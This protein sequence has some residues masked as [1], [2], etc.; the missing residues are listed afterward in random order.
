MANVNHSALTDPYLHEPKGVATASAGEVYVA[1]GSGSGS[2]KEAH[3][4][5]GAYI[6]FDAT[7]PAYQHSTT[8]S[9]T[10]LNPTFTVSV[11]DGF[12]GLTSPN[13]RLSYTGTDSMNA[14]ISFTASTKQS[15]GSSKDVQWVFYK[16]GVELAGSR[17][18]RSISTGTWG[19]ITVLG[20]TT[21]AT[22]DYI[23]VFT[24]AD[25]ACTVD[26]ASG[27]LKIMGVPV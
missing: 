6:P 1:N 25:G 5:I 26:Y 2:W 15:S 24:L 19:S 8:T 22:N 14:A 20:Y 13:A 11:S 4:F 27:F 9:A 12:T 21:L 7:T 16:N 23:E 17:T 10:V 3:Q 18:I